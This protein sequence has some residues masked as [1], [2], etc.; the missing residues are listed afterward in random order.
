MNMDAETKLAEMD[1]L[2]D[3][4]LEY[5]K[6]SLSMQDSFGISRIQRMMR[7]GYNRSAHLVD[8]AIEK[9]ILV[10][11]PAREWLVKFNQ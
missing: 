7:I 6:D 2:D 10:R 5:L 4:Y 8:R 3:E 9:G 1:G 11:D